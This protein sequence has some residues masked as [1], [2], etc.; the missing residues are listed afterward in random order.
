MTL[1]V[2][3]RWRSWWRR[4]DV[5]HQYVNKKFA[6]KYKP[7]IGAVFL[8]KEVTIDDKVV[9]LQIWNTANQERQSLG[10]TFYRKPTGEERPQAQFK[11]LHEKV[12]DR[13]EERSKLVKDYGVVVVPEGLIEFIPEFG[14]L[15]TEINHEL[16]APGVE[17]TE[18]AVLAVRLPGTCRI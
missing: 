14:S 2:W 8:A 1:L 10:V 15:I 11:G 17:S 9:A 3:T 13:I 4:Q 16:G 6:N 7:T 5:S 12:A 18:E